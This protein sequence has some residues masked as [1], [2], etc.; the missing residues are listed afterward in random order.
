MYLKNLSIRRQNLLPYW[1][2][3]ERS[4]K[5]R[6]RDSDKNQILQDLMVAPGG[7]GFVD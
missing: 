2:F 4:I 7:R 5:N 1:M 6:N 3:T